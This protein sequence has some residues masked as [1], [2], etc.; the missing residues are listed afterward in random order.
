MHEKE[1]PAYIILL[2]IGIILI[3]FLILFIV[4]I[5]KYHKRNIELFKENKVAEING[6]EIERKRISNDLHD[7][8]ASTLTGANMYLQVVKGETDYDK[9]IISKIQ[10]SLAI[11]LEQIKQIMNDLYPVSLDNY[12]LVACLNE[13]I[14]EI[15]QLNAINIIFT[16]TVENI[17]AKILKEHKIHIFRIIKEISQNTIKHAD[18]SVLSLRF[19]QN[20]NK[21]ILETIDQG[22][23]FDGD[24]KAY[25]NKG[26]GLNNII[27]R[28]ELISGEIYLDTR[29]Q[30]GVH[31]T[32]EIPIS[33]ATSQN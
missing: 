29:P 12:G 28:V 17:E 30:K 33:Y 7:E 3:A 13:F 6:K 22:K 11:S 21:I 20:D 23:G 24:D 9:H 26:R 14:E 16:N 5:F 18:S 25:T 19:S 15:N 2:V 10:S 32:I 27:S 31:Y 8:L 1:Y 4:N